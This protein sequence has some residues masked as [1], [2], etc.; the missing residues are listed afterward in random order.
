MKGAASEPRLF[1]YRLRFNIALSYCRF[2]NAITLEM[3]YRVATLMSLR[4]RSR[5]ELG[6]LARLLFL[7]FFL[8]PIIAN[9]QQRWLSVTPA[10]AL[11][12]QTSGGYVDRKDALLWYA[13]FGDDKKPAV[14]LLHGGGGNSNTWGH[15]IRDLMRDYRVVVFD[16]RGQ[17]RSTNDAP[18]I[19][20]EQM[21]QDAIAVLGQLGIEKAAVVGW[22]D[23]ANI[24]FY[25]ALRQPQ[26]ITALVAFAGNATPAGYQPNSNPATMAAYAAATRAEYQWLSPHPKKF[27]EV[28][29]LLTAMWKSQPTLTNDELAAIK[30]RTVILHAEHDEII[31]RAHSQELAKQIPNAKFI[32]LRGVSHFAP[33]QNP[34]GFN[35][36]VRAFLVAR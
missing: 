34:N 4:L 18:A 24:G 36:S 28:F 16:C 6:L 13:T 29:Q 8:F 30:A 2:G 14:L 23:G 33:L 3:Q 12:A 17:G 35:A 32:L 22:S 31:R 5:V 27:S 15:L 19:S 10:P 25:L 7:F 11:P 26:R 21:A 1:L 9:A 20:Y